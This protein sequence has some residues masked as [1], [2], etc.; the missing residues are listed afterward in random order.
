[1]IRISRHAYPHLTVVSITTRAVTTTLYI[2]S[3][4][5]LS[6]YFPDYEEV[7]LA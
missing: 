6:I 4:L 1:M 5:P 2:F 7:E 3:K